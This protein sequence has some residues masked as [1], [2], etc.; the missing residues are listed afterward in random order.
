MDCA[1]PE[2]TASKDIQTTA[3]RTHR[4]RDTEAGEGRCRAVWGKGGAEGEGPTG[5][6]ACASYGMTYGHIEL[7]VADQIH[8]NCSYIQ[9]NTVHSMPAPGKWLVRVY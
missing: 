2:S 1:H 7:P 4:T 3:A 6:L 9:T 5:D 8:I